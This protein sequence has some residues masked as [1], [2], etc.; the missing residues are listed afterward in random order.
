MK[1]HRLILCAL[2]ASLALFAPASSDDY[3]AAQLGTKFS[4][5]YLQDKPR[6]LPSASPTPPQSAAKTTSSLLIRPAFRIS[7][8]STVLV[9][10]GAGS[11]DIVFNPDDNEYLVVWESNGL[12]EMKGVNDIYGRRLNAITNERIGFDFRISKLSDADKNHTSSGP[13]IAYNRTAHEYLVVWSGSGLFHSPDRFFEIYGQRLSG[14]GKDIGGNF[15]ISHLTDLG[16]VNTSFVRGSS[17]PHI[18]WNNTNNEYLVVWKGMGEPEDVVKMEIY[19]QRLKANGGLLGK[20]FRISH[21]TD[22]GNNFQTNAPAIAYNSHDDQYLVV[23]SGSFKNESQLEVWGRGLSATGEALGSTGDFRVSQ[24]TDVGANRRATFPRVVYN[25]SN[26]EYFVVFQ[27]N[28][29]RGEGTEGA[30]EI[31]GQR[32]EGTFAETGPN[33][34]RVSNSVDAGSRASKPAV[35]FNTVAKEYLVIW[36]SIRKNASYEI[37]GQ[38]LSSAGMEIEADFQIST[39][40]ALGED[41]S[42]NNSSLTHNTGNGEFLVV[43]QGNSLPGANAAKI[44]EI[45]GQRLVLA[46]SQRP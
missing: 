37:S 35:T 3:L 10:R 12:T 36:R 6:Q 38:R 39:I 13:Q 40:A 1:I 11:A 42:V 4:F 33:D 25:S 30:N 31:F 43:W 29:L 28:A 17:Q 44:T 41:R 14:T 5:L 19:G 7:E 26:N 8:T 20:Y 21:T 32:I 22:Q 16:K 46:R 18:T 45:F 24:V 23:W 2:L 34:F 27:A 9:D 15:R